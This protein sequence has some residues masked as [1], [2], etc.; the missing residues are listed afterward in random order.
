MWSQSGLVGFIHSSHCFGWTNQISHFWRNAI[1]WWE[2]C[3]FCYVQ[4][5]L[6][7]LFTGA[8]YKD[9]TDEECSEEVAKVTANMVKAFDYS[10]G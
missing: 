4:V 1:L 7:S 9:V 2:L 6:L 3:Y 5:K 8:D 10:E